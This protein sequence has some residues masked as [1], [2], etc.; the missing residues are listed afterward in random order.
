[1]IRS[2]L[3]KIFIALHLITQFFMWVDEGYYDFRWMNDPGNWVV[4]F[5]YTSFTFSVQFFFY[6]VV[7]NSVQRA[8][9][10]GLLSFVSGLTFVVLLLWG[11]YEWNRMQL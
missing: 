6:R 2:E 4:Y 7:F 1:M 9:L 5:L 10:R 11:I 8:K 3:F